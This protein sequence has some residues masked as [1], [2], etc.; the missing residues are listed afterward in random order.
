MAVEAVTHALRWI[1]S[2]GDSQTTDALILTDSVSLLE[3]VKSGMGSL[4][5]DVSKTPSC[6]EIHFRKLLWVY[7]PG[8]AGVKKN[9]R[10]ID[11][12]EKQPPQVACLSE[13]LKC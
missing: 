8:H 10:Q 11:Q 7:C 12:R 2:T 13:D 5:S 4:D 6:V 3:K 1:I 9:D